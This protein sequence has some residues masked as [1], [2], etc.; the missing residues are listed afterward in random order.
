MVGI[1]VDHRK[2]SMITI[3][4]PFTALGDFVV[5]LHGHPFGAVVLVALVWLALAWVRGG[6]RDGK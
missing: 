2:K 4:D 5:V 3:T 1:E 6:K